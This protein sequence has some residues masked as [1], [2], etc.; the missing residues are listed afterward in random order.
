VISLLDGLTMI[1][2]FTISGQSKYAKQRESRN[3]RANAN[4]LTPEHG[5]YLRV[6][7]STI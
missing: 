3:E 2:A 6:P 7:D 4:E 5:Q 1:A